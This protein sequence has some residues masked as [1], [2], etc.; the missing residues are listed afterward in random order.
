LSSRS[1]L[2]ILKLAVSK[3]VAVLLGMNLSP[4]R[5]GVV[6]L[7]PVLFGVLQRT[8]LLRMLFSMPL[9]VLLGVLFRASAMR[10]L[11]CCSELFSAV[12]FES[13]NREVDIE[14]DEALRRPT[15]VAKHRKLIN[16]F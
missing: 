13:A 14:E 7:L 6:V 9:G 15:Y 12:L 2:V 5:G 11:P 1:P 16:S 8:D 4:P 3:S 10:L